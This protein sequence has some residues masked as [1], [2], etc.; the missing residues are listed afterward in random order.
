[1]MIYLTHCV[2]IKEMAVQI[3]MFIAIHYKNIYTFPLYNAQD[4]PTIVIGMCIHLQ[5]SGEMSKLEIE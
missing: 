5:T 3:M 1:M 2:S 4:P